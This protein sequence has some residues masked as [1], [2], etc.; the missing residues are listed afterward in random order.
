[1]VLP[2]ATAQDAAMISRLFALFLLVPIAALAPPGAARADDSPIVV[3]LFTSQ[4]CSSC[5]PADKYLT[6]LAK[7]PDVMALAFHIEYW[8]YI[9]WP[10]PYSKPWA[11][12]RQREYIAKLKQRFIYTP[13]IVVQ[14]TAEA[15][16]SE[17][18]TVEALIRA[19][20]SKRLPHPDLKLRWREDGSLLVNVGNGPSP[21]GAPATLWLLGYDHL[22]T[23]AV[24]AGENEG[25]TAMNPN[26]VR[27]FRRLGAW[28]GWSEELIVSADE[29]KTLGDDCAVVIL[30]LDG[31]GPIL[32]AAD[33]DMPGS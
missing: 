8:N 21:Q 22:H 28:A 31:N 15:V 3:E 20:A 18:G 29:A 12:R 11:T 33:I 6:E 23:N 24:L 25:K 4:G 9:G 14:G 19:A 7:R 26:P 1:L 17:R 10:D 30:Q 16:G 32:T 27:A 2:V 13:E 5:P